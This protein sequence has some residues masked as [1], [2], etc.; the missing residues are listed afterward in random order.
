VRLSHAIRAASNFCVALH[1]GEDLHFVS[2][3]AGLGGTTEQIHF[4]AAGWAR[5]PIFDAKRA[6]F[7]HADWA[8]AMNGKLWFGHEES[9]SIRHPPRDNI[10][11]QLDWNLFNIAQRR[12]TDH[13]RANGALGDTDGMTPTGW[14]F[15]SWR[16]GAERAQIDR[17]TWH[18]GQ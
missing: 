1:T 2:V 12:T 8:F 16:L 14:G 9:P 5:G 15:R 7:A 18:A 13:G 11:P 4:S 17:P 6:R 10:A 3:V